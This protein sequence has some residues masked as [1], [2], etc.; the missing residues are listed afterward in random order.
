MGELG[1]ERLLSEII[2]DAN[3]D[4]AGTLADGGINEI[5][6]PLDIRAL[7]YAFSYGVSWDES[8]ATGGYT[9]T[10]MTA[11]AA[12]GSSPPDSLIPIQVAMRRCVM[13]DSGVVQT[14]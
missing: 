2:I 1:A 6:T 14:T 4:L 11:L 9:R 7:G 13:N 8:Q 3:A 10:G 12:V 5:T